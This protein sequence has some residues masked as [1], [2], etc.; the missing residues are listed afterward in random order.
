MKDMISEEFR[1]KKESTFYQ[2]DIK[3]TLNPKKTIYNREEPEGNNT[4]G[5]GVSVSSQQGPIVPVNSMA[6]N[7][8]PN[9]DK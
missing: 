8:N 1:V 2:E 4:N 9:Y 3:L 7:Q 5:G 6:F